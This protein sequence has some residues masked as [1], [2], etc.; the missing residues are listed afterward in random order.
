[1]NTQTTHYSDFWSSSSESVDQLLGLDTAKKKGKDPVELAAYKRAISNFCNIMTGQSIPVQFKGADSYTD[2]KTI[3][4]SSTINENN[5][6]PTVG[7]ALHEAAHIV[8]SDFDFLRNLDM[9]IPQQYY[10]LAERKGVDKFVAR[11]QIKTLLNYIEDRRIDYF[12]FKTSPGYKGYYHEMYNK[13]FY[14]KSI[15]KM[16]ISTMMRETTWESYEARIINL[17]NQNTQLTA[18]PGLKEIYSIIN[19]KNI[20]RLKSSEDAF[21][22][23]LDVYAII[24]KNINSMEQPELSKEEQQVQ[25]FRN[26]LDQDDS[27]ESSS[28]EPLDYQE[29]SSV[30]S[31]KNDD[32]SEAQELSSRQEQMAENAMSKQRSFVSGNV[33]KTKATKK[34]K[35]DVKAIDASGATYEQVGDDIVDWKGRSGTRCLVVKKLTKQLIDSNQFRVAQSYNG[36]CYDNDRYDKQ[37]F[38]EE[39]MRLGMM[40]GKKLQV[41]GE[42]TSL[43]F[44]RKNAGKLDRRLISELGFNNSNVFSQTITT[45][46][47]KAYLHISV[48]ASGSMYGSCWNNAMTSAIAMIKAA[49]MVG[50]IDVVM[51]IRSTH[52]AGSQEVPLI[53]VCYDSRQDKI[54]KVKSLFK[55]LNTAGTTPEGL[56]FEA[57]MKDLVPGN[58]NQDSYFINYS[59]GQPYFGNQDISYSGPEAQRHTAKMVMKMRNQGMKVMS[60]FIGADC[61]YGYDRDRDAFKTMYGTDASFIKAT[62]MM[63]VAKTMNAKFLDK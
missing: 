18:L 9:N 54:S 21:K 4:I 58:S 30:D 14:S 1:M 61:D 31:T 40:L 11:Q 63:E 10:L 60:Y 25:D 50:N 24:M 13:Y 51:S 27:Q 47:N 44:T 16:L 39:G 41:R 36:H 46:Y 45:R 19:L 62:N 29:S 52:E 43:K 6:D 28:G 23:A 32:G 38:V 8:L 53:M 26:A 42:E 33:Q 2:G 7:L 17:H 35:N 55:Y 5:F 37:N 57:I 20:S 34:L 22:V 59:D 3:T 48:D 56:C 49:D 12:V 15:D